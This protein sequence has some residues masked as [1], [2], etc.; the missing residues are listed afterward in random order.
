MEK[1]YLKINK[2]SWNTKVKY[3]VESDFYDVK[4]FL[5]GKSSL[6]DI[7]LQL[8]S[9][10]EGKSILHLQCH[11]GQ[12]SISLARLGAKVTA[13]DLS[14]ESINTALELNEQTK[15]DVTFI[16]CDVYS[17][18]KHLNEQ[19]DIVFTS[20]GT[21]G[22]LP[23][24]NKWADIISH[25]L[26]PNGQFVFAEFH[27][28]IWMYDDDFKYIAYDYFNNEAIIETYEGT[29]ADKDAKI[30]QQYVMWNHGLSEVITALIEKGLRIKVF[31]EYNFSPYDFTNFTYEDEPKKYRIKGLDKKVPLV[32]AIEA[33]KQNLML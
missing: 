7:E 5:N 20:Y 24:I 19:F 1:D 17:L 8:L 27:P 14:N 15:T 31:K 4:G 25:F 12:D 13:V 3:H 6:N 28:V 10:I 22:W 30:E 32:Y 29:Y 18:P 2:V 23:D 11:F 33:I 9:N 16:N 21:I 26:K